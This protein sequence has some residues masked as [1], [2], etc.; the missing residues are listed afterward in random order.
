MITDT[1]TARPLILPNGVTKNVLTSVAKVEGVPNDVS[2]ILDKI[3]GQI[4]DN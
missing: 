3:V 1:W 2:T 4:L